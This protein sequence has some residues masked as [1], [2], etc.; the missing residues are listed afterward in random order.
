V[1]ERVEVGHIDAGE[2]ASHREALAFEAPRRR[3]EGLHATW[4]IGGLGLDGLG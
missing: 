3:R 2:G 4:S 1:N